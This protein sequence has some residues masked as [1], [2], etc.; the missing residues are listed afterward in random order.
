MSFEEDLFKMLSAI[1]LFIVGVAQNNKVLFGAGV[2]AAGGYLVYQGGK[3]VYNF[4]SDKIEEWK[5]THPPPKP[6]IT[7]ITQSNEEKEKEEK[8]EEKEIKTTLQREVEI[9]K[10]KDEDDISNLREDINELQSDIE[11]GHSTTQ[12]KI[13]LKRKK[14]QL[15]KL[16]K[17]YREK[18]H[19]DPPKET[20][21]LTD[22]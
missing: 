14:D 2:V 16:E 13:E 21:A 17:S 3:K 18:Y 7:I 9:Q 11:N 1:T 22:N 15:K 20:S 12:K 19:E 5:R 6:P 4:A 8:E 10:K